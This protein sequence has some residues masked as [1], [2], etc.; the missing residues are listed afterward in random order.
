MTQIQTIW[1]PKAMMARI[2][3]ES[4]MLVLTPPR[5]LSFQRRRLLAQNAQKDYGWAM[6]LLMVLLRDGL[7]LA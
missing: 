2:R 7:E 3:E 1:A 5:P 6:S 4:G